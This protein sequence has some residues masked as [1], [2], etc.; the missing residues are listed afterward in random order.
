MTIDILRHASIRAIL[1]HAARIDPE[2]IRSVGVKRWIDLARRAVLPAGSTPDRAADLMEATAGG[3]GELKRH[4]GIKGWQF[5]VRKPAFALTLCERKALA[6]PLGL[7]GRKSTA[8][9]KEPS[10]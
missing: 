10:R 3:G 8:A 9:H 2:P 7:C 6:W 4:A 5:R 1:T